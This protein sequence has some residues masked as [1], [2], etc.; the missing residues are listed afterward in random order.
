[1]QPV[2]ALFLLLAATLGQFGAAAGARAEGAIKDIR[3][4]PH[5]NGVRMVLD[6]GT[7]VPFSHRTL[8]NPP[9]LVIDLPELA[10]AVPAGSNQA[11]RMVEGLRFGTFRDDM[12]RLVL[13]IDRPFE[14]TKIL[15]LPPG[16]GYGYRVV[17]FLAP[18]PVGT[19]MRH[20]YVAKELDRTTVSS[21]RPAPRRPARAFASPAP[22]PRPGPPR[23]IIVLDPGHGGIDPGA[24]GLNGT[25]E[26]DVVL[27]LA[28]E[29]RNQ[30]IESGRYDVI[31]T[32]EDDTFVRLRDRLQ[33]ARASEGHLF[34]SLHADSLQNAEEVKG[35]A[36]YTLSEQASSEEAAL[37]ASNE[38]RADILAGVDL[39]HHE[40]I[41]TQI[42]ID[43]AQRDANRKSVQ[44][45]DLL[46]SELGHVTNMLRHE[47][48]QA[49]FV[50]LKSPDMPS[51]LIELGYL[52]N[53]ED[54]RRLR[55][56]QHRSAL[57]RSIMTAI[58]RFFGAE[59]L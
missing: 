48:Q 32:R 50:V 31:L 52:S 12:V 22:R 13:D 10:W 8:D 7:E 40:Q 25:L 18:L 11:L 41:V 4:L 35:A 44:V 54:E 43:L 2:L 49:G 29:L 33:I 39:S 20:Q 19:P 24:S 28:H 47:R 26:K 58:D 36:I 51:A 16:Y 55:D 37:L 17:T 57:A 59:P 30:L 23:R 15:E 46:L 3:L 14:I 45:A 56:G 27:A 6:L 53:S 21:I 5:E 1:M 34:L 42:L 9:R 38:N